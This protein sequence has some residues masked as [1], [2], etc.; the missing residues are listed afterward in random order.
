MVTKL[1]DDILDFLL[2]MMT[3]DIIYPHYWLKAFMFLIPLGI[4]TL[5]VFIDK[6]SKKEKVRNGNQN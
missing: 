6:L 2:E 4:C 1:R 3:A 5:C